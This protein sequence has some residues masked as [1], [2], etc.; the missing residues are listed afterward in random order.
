[1]GEGVIKKTIIFI[2]FITTI[3]IL[4]M[5]AISAQ[6]IDENQTDNFKLEITETADGATQEVLSVSDQ[7]TLESDR[8]DATGAYLVLDNDA[9]KENV[10]VGD[11]VTW[12]LEA[13]N[14]GPDTAKNVK[15]HDRLPQGLKYIKHTAT[16]GTFNPQNGIWDIGNLTIEEGL[17]SLYIT[18]K[19]IT[20]GEKINEATITSDT[21]NT[22][23]E[24]FE[25]E[26]IDVFAGDDSQT[27]GF[28]KHASAKMHETGNPL[29]LIFCS[30]LLFTVS[31]IKRKD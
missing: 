7:Q 14:F 24:T 13:Q 9:D 17:V 20:I 27:S 4:S 12:I 18:T 22:N 3:V 31:I 15:I 19:A 29:F 11:Y 16:K 21:T 1:M 10:N 30:L 26:E 2:L 28:E 8:K 5:A 23:N 25:E 6:E